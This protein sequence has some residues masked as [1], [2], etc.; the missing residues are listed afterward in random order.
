MRRASWRTTAVADQP[1][2]AAIV[3]TATRLP[4]AED[5]I[6]GAVTVITRR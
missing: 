2:V 3:V 1:A 6:P 4:V 5:Q